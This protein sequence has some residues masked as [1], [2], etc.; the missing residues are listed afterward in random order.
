MLELI[1]CIKFAYLPSLIKKKK[2]N[3]ASNKT[4]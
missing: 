2:V 3:K 4:T 1:L